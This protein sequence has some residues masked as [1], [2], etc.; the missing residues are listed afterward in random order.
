MHVQPCPAPSLRAFRDRRGSGGDLL[1]WT[2][3]CAFGSIHRFHGSDHRPWTYGNHTEDV[4]RSYLK[5]RYA[6]MPSLIAAGQVATET[7]F[8]LVARGDFY[9]PDHANATSNHQYVKFRQYFLYFDCLE[10]DLRAHT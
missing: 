3:H 10:L 2:A 6:L 7:A 1:R 8:P 5:M 9:W 4:I